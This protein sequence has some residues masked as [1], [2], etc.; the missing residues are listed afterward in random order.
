VDLGLT[1]QRAIVVGTSH[2][3]GLAGALVRD[4]D[5]KFTAT[6]DAVF[7]S[8]RLERRPRAA[9]DDSRHPRLS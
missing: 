5:S 4:R 7:A 8:R 6:F 1:A 3:I 9:A 2:G